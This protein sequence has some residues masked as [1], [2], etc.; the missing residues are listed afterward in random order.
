MPITP[1]PRQAPELDTRQEPPG[2][3]PKFVE[4]LAQCL[5]VQVPEITDDTT[6][7]NVAALMASMGL[8]WFE[9]NARAE[10]LDHDLKRVSYGIEIIRD[11]AGSDPI[12]G[13][14]QR[15]IDGRCTVHRRSALPFEEG[16]IYQA[17]EIYCRTPHSG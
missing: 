10:A 12:D 6:R 9:A 14:C 15:D 11:L 16:C 2:P 8:S 5:K 4:F 3:D 17:A 13:A 7:A 1:D